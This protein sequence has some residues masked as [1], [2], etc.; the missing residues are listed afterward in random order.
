MLRFSCIDDQ[1]QTYINGVF[2]VADCSGQCVPS[3]KD[4]S[5]AIALS[6][7]M[8]IGVIVGGLVLG[9]VGFALVLRC[10]DGNGFKKRGG[11]EIWNPAFNDPTYVNTDDDDEHLLGDSGY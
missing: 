9:A 4:T 5:A 11:A 8:L 1:C 2:A 10:K 3:D 6:T 7:G